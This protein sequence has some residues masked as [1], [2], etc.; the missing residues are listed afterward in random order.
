M[1]EKGVSSLWE[2]D[3]PSLKYLDLRKKVMYSGKNKIKISKKDLTT[4]MKKDK[5]I[6][7][8]YSD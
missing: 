2:M 1:T 8:Q 6:D 7:V 4:Q 5:N 3:L